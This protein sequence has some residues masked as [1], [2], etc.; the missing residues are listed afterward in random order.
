M[1]KEIN[2]KEESREISKRGLN[3]TRKKTKKGGK[4]QIKRAVK[5]KTWENGRFK[6]WLRANTCIYY[7]M[8]C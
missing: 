5:Q 1:K 7:W 4:R 8:Y 2:K 3:F 6:E